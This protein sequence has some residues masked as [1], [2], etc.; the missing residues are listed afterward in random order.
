[1]E[2][3][4]LKWAAMALLSVVVYFLKRTL[5]TVEKRLDKVETEQA[6]IPKSYLHRDDFK[7]FKIELRTMFDEIKMDIKELKQK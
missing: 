5:D 3:E 6:E 7:E 4:A 2:V 1:M